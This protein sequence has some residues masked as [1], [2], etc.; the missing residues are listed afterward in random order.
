MWLN[1][2]LPA[3]EFDAIGVAV[4]GLDAVGLRRS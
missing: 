4:T 1:A 3:S 2:W